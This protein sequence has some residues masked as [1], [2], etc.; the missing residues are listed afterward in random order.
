M[1]KHSFFRHGAPPG[2]VMLRSNILLQT[3]GS[4]GAIPAP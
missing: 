4:Y 2:L 3:L 1:L